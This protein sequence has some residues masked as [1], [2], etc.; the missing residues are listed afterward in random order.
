MGKFILQESEK[1]QIRQMYGLV[2]E[3]STP[4]TNDEFMKW[5]ETITIS[6]FVAPNPY[7]NGPIKLGAKMT[8]YKKEDDA[9]Y[10]V[11]KNLIEQL[12]VVTSDGKSVY[13]QVSGETMLFNGDNEYK[14]IIGD[15]IVYYFLYEDGSEVVKNLEKYTNRNK[16]TNFIVTVTPRPTDNI[17]LDKLVLFRSK[18]TTLIVA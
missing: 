14:E 7:K 13:Q 10:Q 6:A 9:K 8:P 15:S 12:N 4:E 3:Q 5:L 17:K 2:N 16:T 1:E 11:A 18:P